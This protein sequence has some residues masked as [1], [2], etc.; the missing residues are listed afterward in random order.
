M[1]NQTHD[2]TTSSICKEVISAGKFSNIGQRISIEKSTLLLDQLEIGKQKYIDLKRLLKADSVLLPAYKD[3]ALYRTEITL[4]NELQYIS[5]SDQVVTGITIPYQLLLR[6]TVSRLLSTLPNLNDDQYPLILRVSDGLD[7]SGSHQIYN[8]LQTSVNFSTKNFL[9]FAFK[10]LSIRD[11]SDREVWVNTVPNSHFQVRPVALIAMKENE[12][13]VKYLMESHINPETKIIENEGI[14]LPQGLVKVH[15]IRSMF[16]GKMSGI[17][18]GAGGA[19]CQLCT[20]TF[21]QISDLELIRTGFPINRTISAAKEI[22]AT[23]DKDEY[24]ALPSHERFGLTHEPLS[25]IDV[26]SASPL[27]SYTCVFRWYMTL[28]YHLQSGSKKWSPKSAKVLSS[29]KF[30]REFLQEKNWSEDRPTI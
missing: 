1:A 22:F 24:L 29:L 17:L 23:V 6:Q 20:A 5:N 10:L 9:L 26:I 18:T 12:E 27:H 3:V 14:N 4:A 16:D 30:V 8:Q 15:V 7:G 28:V 11:T 2:Q 25:E 21:D 19:K 13:N